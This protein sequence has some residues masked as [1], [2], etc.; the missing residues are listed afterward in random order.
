MQKEL[1][2]KIDKAVFPGIQGGPHEHTIFAKTIAFQEAQTKSFKDY[3][4]QVARNAQVLAKELINK[5]FNL[6]TGGT[7]NHLM[8]ID[9][10]NKNI[11]G[12]EAQ[13]ILEKAHILANRN[14]VR[15][16]KTLLNQVEFA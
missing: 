11:D 1:A 5:G 14:T 15:A 10:K 13:N 3:Q 4:K 8:L 16:M 12:T 2:S 7:D 6:V 9:L